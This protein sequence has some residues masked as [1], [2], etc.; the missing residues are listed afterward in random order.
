MALSA[1]FIELVNESG[2]DVFLDKQVIVN[3]LKYH[4]L[5][6]R[7][8]KPIV[9]ACLDRFIFHKYKFRTSIEEI[10]YLR[11]K[12]IDALEREGFAKE[13]VVPV[14]NAFVELTEYVKDTPIL[15]QMQKSKESM[16][17]VL[18]SALRNYERGMY[19]SALTGF[20][21]LAQTDFAEASFYMG[22]CYEEGK[23]IEKDEKKA[24]QFY[25]KG[26][27]N[28]STNAM[29][30]LGRC[31]EEG[32]GL[33]I[34]HARALEMFKESADKGNAPASLW[35]GKKYM[36]QK[37]DPRKADVAVRCLE[38]SAKQG[39][40]EAALALAEY[41]MTLAKKA[42]GL[43][44]AL[45]W[46]EFLSERGN[47]D[48]SYALHKIYED[49]VAGKPDME[50]SMLYVARAAA[51]GHNDAKNVIQELSTLLDDPDAPLNFDGSAESKDRITK[52]ARDGEPQAQY[53]LAMMYLEGNG[54]EKNQQVAYHW[55]SLANKQDYEP[56]QKMIGTACYELGMSYYK[57]TNGEQRDYNKA[58]DC[59]LNGIKNEKNNSD[60]LNGNLYMLLGLCN[61]SGHGTPKNDAMAANYFTFAA[62]L[63]R[64]E[65]LLYAAKIYETGGEK[66][67]DLE[68]ALKTYLDYTTA[69][70]KDKKRE[71]SALFE[72][73]C[74]EHDDVKTLFPAE[75]FMKLAGMQ[76]PEA[77]YY[78]GLIYEEGT[79]EVIPNKDICMEYY[80]AASKLGH[81]EAYERL[82]RLK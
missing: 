28:G 42:G 70:G 71:I 16:F 54:V 64:K 40:D 33:T 8:Q 56:A 4:F 52:G 26:A 66:V 12:H 17:L 53:T 75:T 69:T 77:L 68:K 65:A 50:R 76:I 34:D 14:V 21:S 79:G 73:I 37:N 2:Q 27:H 61:Y 18:I 22:K 46:Y 41:F 48:A 57:G 6:A 74:A 10:L 25:T 80:E 32:I 82:R 24:I 47:A 7:D 9:E 31:F 58:M 1:K 20:K 15:S 29:Y 36:E 35:L 43:D 23:A 59:F 81:L 72:K 19:A 39:F 30:A 3:K 45:Y 5:L 51:Q 49:G 13:S 67:S 38:K 78:V 60:E 11:S 55:M 44:R 63:G 62:K